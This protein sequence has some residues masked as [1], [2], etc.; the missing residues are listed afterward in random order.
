MAQEFEHLRIEK[1]PINNPRRSGRPPRFKKRSDLVGHGQKL[2]GVLAST[3]QAVKQQLTS[4]PGH[5]VLKLKY[6]DALSFNELVAHGVEFVS[7]EDSHICVVFTTEQGLATFSDHLARLGLDDKDIT[8]KQLLEALTSIEAWNAEDR[9]SWALKQYGLPQDEMFTLDVEL[10]PSDLSA[11][12]QRKELVD[13]FEQ[14][15][16]CNSIERKDK[17]NLDSLLMYRLVVDR[18][19]V[20]KLLNHSD[21]RFIDLP[22]RSGI[23]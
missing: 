23:D 5:Y 21:V 17:V 14:W 2:S 22:P 11:S 16:V 13:A 19:G 15:L 3:T 18:N 10:W 1:E 7:Q 20:E 6:E 8:R 9:K 12:P 4:R